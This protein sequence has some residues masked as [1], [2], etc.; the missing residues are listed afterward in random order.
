MKIKENSSIHIKKGKTEIT[1]NEQAISV[2]APNI[3]L[4][5]LSDEK[6][7]SVTTV[8]KKGIVSQIQ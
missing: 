8:T 4:T 2:S 6:T 1:V 5:V 3:S 7:T